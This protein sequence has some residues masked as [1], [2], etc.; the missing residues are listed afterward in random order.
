MFAHLVVDLLVA[1]IDLGAKPSGISGR[2]HFSRICV[3]VLSDRQHLHLYRCEPHGQTARMVFKKDARE[4]LEGAE[5][6][7]VDHHRRVLF[8]V[9]ADVAGTKTSRQVQVELDGSALPV[10]PD[11]VAKDELQLGSVEGP[12]ARI[13]APFLARCFE[14]GPSHKRPC[15][16]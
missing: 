9:L 8:S 6:G 3:S 14:G 13:E 2:E 5:Q 7:A 12:L 16:A 4:A 1:K 11:C 15:T 10:T